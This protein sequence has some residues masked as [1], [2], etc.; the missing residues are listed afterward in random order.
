MLS[1]LEASHDTG[2][3]STHAA[4]LGAIPED[5]QPKQY[6]SI[7]LCGEILQFTQRATVRGAARG[8]NGETRTQ[9]Q[10]DTSIVLAN[11]KVATAS[12]RLWFQALI[13]EVGVLQARVLTSNGLS[14]AAEMMSDSEYEQFKSTWQPR[15]L[16]PQ[17]A[18]AAVPAVASAG[19]QRDFRLAISVSQKDKGGPGKQAAAAG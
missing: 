1:G 3:L 15:P 13:L 8:G 11:N 2:G 10:Y 12:I 18:L 17:Q 5:P 4:Q 19:F 14:E 6:P 7:A 9:L 16:R